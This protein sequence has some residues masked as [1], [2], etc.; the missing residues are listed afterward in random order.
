MNTYLTRWLAA[1][2]GAILVVWFAAPAQAGAGPQQADRL[3]GHGQAHGAGVLPAWARPHG[4]SLEDMARITA[5]FNVSD[6]GG[7]LPNTP[8]QILY[9]SASS[10]DPFRVGQ[11]TIL[12]VP[13]AYNDDSQP[14]IGDFPR[15][16]ENRLELL[17]YWY[18]QRQWGSVY[19]DIVVD[20]K[21]YPLGA[22]YLAGVRFASPLP[23]GARQYMTPAAFV[24]P[25][26][27]GA[28]TVE[29]RLKATGDAFRE[30]PVSQYF[31]DGFFEFST[32]YNVVVY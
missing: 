14:V 28:H 10:P 30:E 9:S 13:V 2:A 22:R 4:Y 32:V 29:I 11:G 5:P 27:R 1:L 8:F 20:G 7:P 23:D 31:P 6:R 18:S 16:V 15:N 3:R 25:L 21:V 19:V 12:Y 26:A 24:G 17:R